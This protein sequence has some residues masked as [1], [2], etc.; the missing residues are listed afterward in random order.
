[1]RDG[2][3]SRG[4]S[5]LFK[6]R[7]KGVGISWRAIVVLLWCFVVP[8]I[9]RVFRHTEEQAFFPLDL[10][11]D[12]TEALLDVHSDVIFSAEHLNRLAG[13][14]ALHG[15]FIP[16]ERALATSLR[17]HPRQG[18]A[19]YLLGALRCAAS[20]LGELYMYVYVHIYICICIF[21]YI[22]TY[23]HIYI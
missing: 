14:L 17:L 11:L 15:H 8:G 16:A 21:I 4:N 10:V 9:G 18:D 12:Q 22:Y 1:M 13:S 7:Q 23:I 20:R 6:S 2:G 5:P 19:L 3:R